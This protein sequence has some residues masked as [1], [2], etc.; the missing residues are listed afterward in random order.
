MRDDEENQPVFEKVP[1][2]AWIVMVIAV[3]AC[4]SYTDP[5]E[6]DEAVLH[7]NLREINLQ[8]KQEIQKLNDVSDNENHIDYLKDSETRWEYRRKL[9]RQ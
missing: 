5:T 4:C 2:W 7:E 9:Y 1:V 3:C 8:R 6:E